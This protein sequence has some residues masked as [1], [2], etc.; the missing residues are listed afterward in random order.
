MR[1][2]IYEY[3]KDLVHKYHIEYSFGLK[4]GDAEEAMKA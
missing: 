1:C 3:D 2:F 4:N